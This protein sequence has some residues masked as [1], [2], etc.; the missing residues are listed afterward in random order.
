MTSTGRLQTKRIIGE[1]LLISSLPGK[2]LITLVESRGLLNDSTCALKA[3]LG[4]LD[5][6]RQEPGI[7]FISFP[8]SSLFELA[9]MM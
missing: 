2:A 3:K 6:K 7:L 9:I 5:V 8:I 1:C 4:K